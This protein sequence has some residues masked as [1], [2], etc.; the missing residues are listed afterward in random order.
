MGSLCTPSA[1]CLC[2]FRA[3]L[4]LEEWFLK[5]VQ[6]SLKHLPHILR[7]IWLEE[8]P[9][10]VFVPSCLVCAMFLVNLVLL[11]FGVN[12][13]AFA[14][15]HI[16]SETNS[17]KQVAKGFI[18][19]SVRKTWLIYLTSNLHKVTWKLVF[20]SF[21]W[22]FQDGPCPFKESW[23]PQILSQTSAPVSSGRF[24]DS[25]NSHSFPSAKRH[26][27]VSKTNFPRS[28]KMESVIMELWI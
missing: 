24:W 4:N 22:W 10:S 13:F 18:N 9:F 17:P 26:L 19:E 27:P 23:I 16:Y 5:F 14:S 3:F 6:D 15:V 7:S 11:T 8:V 1:L 21:A 2:S 28:S 20:V 12:A 25:Y